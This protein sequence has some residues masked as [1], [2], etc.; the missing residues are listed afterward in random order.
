M[1]R[2]AVASAHTAAKFTI[3]RAVFRNLPLVCLS[4]EWF[5]A[6]ILTLNV[7]KTNIHVILMKNPQNKFQLENEI[8]MNR[9]VLRC[10]DEIKF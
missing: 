5:N 4:S 3:S 7:D 9:A 6:N 1:R 10:V 2:D 8:T